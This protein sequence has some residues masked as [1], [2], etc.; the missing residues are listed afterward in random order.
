[1]TDHV[2]DRSY[3]SGEVKRYAVWPTLVPQTVGS[4][5]WGLY[6]VYWRIFGMPTAEVALYIHLHDAQEIV[7]G[8]NPFP[9]SSKYPSLRK[10]K[11]EM[12]ADASVSLDLP[13]I[14]SQIT[15]LEKA[16][17]KICDLLEMMM[18]GML[19]REM[20]NLLATPIIERTASAALQL[21]QKVLV[22]IS[23]DLGKRLIRFVQ[24]ET[25]RH[26]NVLYKE[27]SAR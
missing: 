6:H 12:E 20:G 9:M 17:V 8:D 2:T 22:G 23:L 25:A 27:G 14:G 13:D 10:A 18:K 11:D 19:E 26:R 5:T 1:M 3:L 16:K 4:H 7:T 21:G 24:I 15:D